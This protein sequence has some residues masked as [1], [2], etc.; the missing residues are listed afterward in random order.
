[1]SS[2][3]KVSFGVLSLGEKSRSAII[4]S[5]ES[6]SRHL[7]VKEEIFQ[8]WLI[9][10]LHILDIADLFCKWHWGPTSLLISYMKLYGHL[11]NLTISLRLPT[12]KVLC[13]PWVHTMGEGG[14]LADQQIASTSR[15][16]WWPT[17]LDYACKHKR[18]TDMWDGMRSICFL[19]LRG[20]CKE[21]FHGD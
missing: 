19:N 13:G 14:P 8:A 12:Q 4:C 11:L 18:T 7:T 15:G 3:I 6:T 5:R 9:I 20:S 16:S 10:K 21:N 1:M 17:E 2:H